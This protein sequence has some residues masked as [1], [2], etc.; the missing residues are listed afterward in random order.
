MARWVWLGLGLLL[1][2][3]PVLAQGGGGGGNRGE[4]SAYRPWQEVVQM[5]V[6]RAFRHTT[7]LLNLLLL[8]LVLLLV[9]TGMGLWW[10]R[11]SIL[12]QLVQ[13]AADQARQPMRTQA[14]TIV[15]EVLAQQLTHYQLTLAALAAQS[16]QA[17]EQEWQKRLHA[18]EVTEPLTAVPPT[19]SPLERLRQ[20]LAQE[21]LE[22]PADL[23]QQLEQFRPDQPTLSAQDCLLLGRVWQRLGRWDHAVAYLQQAS[24]KQPDAWEVWYHLGVAFSYGQRYNDALTCFEKALA[25]QPQASQIQQ[26]REQ[27]LEKMG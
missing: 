16:R 21:S 10:L 15:A 1:A 6:D 4:P 12:Q 7:L 20:W 5:E 18:L 11:R 26:Q 23:S 13:M 27:M 2:M 14:E 22:L 19:P 17:L 8:V 25:L 24:Q 9:A 3:Q